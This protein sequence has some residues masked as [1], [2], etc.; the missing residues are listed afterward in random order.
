MASRLSLLSDGSPVQSVV[1]W[2][3]SFDTS[4]R[5]SSRCGRSGVHSMSV[6]SVGRAKVVFGMPVAIQRTAA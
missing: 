6:T 4:S 5:P 1:G 3:S 2:T